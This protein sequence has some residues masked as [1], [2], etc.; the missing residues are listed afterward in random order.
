AVIT[1]Y[2][3]SYLL[4]DPDTTGMNNL[5]TALQQATFEQEDMQ[6]ALLASNEYFSNAKKGNGNNT[7]FIKSLYRDVLHREA[8]AGEVSG[9]ITYIAGGGTLSSVA[10][11]IVRSNEAYGYVVDRWYQAYLR[12][13][14]DAAAKNSWIA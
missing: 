8:A 14:A 13:F 1:E 4:R 9:W 11:L 6:V 12:R 5:L 7:D 10:S 2:Y 3:R